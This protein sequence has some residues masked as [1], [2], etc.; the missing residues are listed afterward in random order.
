MLYEYFC[1]YLISLTHRYPLRKTRCFNEYIMLNFRAKFG[2][3]LSYY[4][5][6][7]QWHK[8]LLDYIGRIQ[9]K[10]LPEWQSWKD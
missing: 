10:T 7:L 8:R 2:Q 3:P 5:S 4:F 1:D 9:S 6:V